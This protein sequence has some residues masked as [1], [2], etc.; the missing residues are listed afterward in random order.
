M[1]GGNAIKI[2]RKVKPE[3]YRHPNIQGAWDYLASQCLNWIIAE[4]LL[5]KLNLRQSD[6]TLQS[7]NSIHSDSK[8]SGRIGSSCPALPKS[9]AILM[10]R[11]IPILS[12]SQFR[13]S[14]GLCDRSQLLTAAKRKNPDS[15]CRC[16]MNRENNLSKYVS[17][18]TRLFSASGVSELL[19][20]VVLSYIEQL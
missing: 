12:E 10:Q 5:N 18:V 11:Y 17:C 2:R 14:I 19:S 16:M 9:D 20:E 15:P 1:R 3:S 6:A 4:D 13:D 8:Y 7:Y